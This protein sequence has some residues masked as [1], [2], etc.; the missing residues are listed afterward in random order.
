MN[1]IN[2]TIL[3][4]R[5]DRV[6]VNLLYGLVQ[7]LYMVAVCSYFAFLVMY[8]S[9]EGYSE[10]YIGFAMTAV[11]LMGIL[12]PTL[13]GYVADVFIPVKTI[14]AFMMLLSIP[15]AFMLNFTV[16]IIPLAMVSI[17]A[18]GI[19]ERSM[20]SMIDSWGMKIRNRKPYL[21]YGISRGI[22]SM[23][24]ALAGLLLG[25][26]YTIAGIDKLFWVHGVFALLC[27]VAALFLDDVPVVRH[28]RKNGSFFTSVGDLLK[29]RKYVILVI[30]MVLH[31]FSIVAAQTFQPILI[32]GMGGNSTHLGIS[33]FLM[34]G[35]EAPIMFSS[36]SFLRRYRV[37]NLLLVSFLFTVIKLLLMIFAP[38]LTLLIIFQLLQALSFGLYLPSVL[39]YIG[40]ITPDEIQSTAITFALSMGF[41]ISGIAGNI[42]GGII[43][44]HYGVKT[45]ISIFAVLSALGLILFYRSTGTFHFK[46]PFAKAA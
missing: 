43:A 35:S 25:S 17:A 31:G 6:R 1:E 5:K 21:N 37:E 39:F 30:C 14:V 46:N 12:S 27:T 40:L 22:A 9:S 7:S 19:T 20:M 8:L 29:N 11:S 45:V 18:L 3:I 33:I 44:D 15:I 16:G 10:T 34:A 42:F 28:N 24:Y 26:F 2:D 23:A 32:T 13:I 38:N 36:T 41:G 4:N